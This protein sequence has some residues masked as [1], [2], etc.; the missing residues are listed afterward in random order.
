MVADATSSYVLTDPGF[1][2]D[3]R[4]EALSPARATR[5]AEIVATLLESVRVP[6]DAD[7]L[8]LC[9]QGTFQAFRPR[10]AW[11]DW[12]TQQ[13]AV[14]MFRINRCE[15]IERRLRYIQSLRAIDCWEADQR[16]AIDEFVKMLADDPGRAYANLHA[17]V[18]GCD[19]LIDR[20][21]EL[22]E[23][24]VEA[25]TEAQHAFARSIH[26]GKANAHRQP[27]FAAEFTAGLRKHREQVRTTDQALR[28][29]AEADLSTEV[30]PQLKQVRRDRQAYQ[31]QLNW[32][33]KQLHR[34]QPEH[35]TDYRFRP[36]YQQTPLEPRPVVT[37]AE[38]RPASVAGVDQ[39]N[40]TVEANTPDDQTN[41]TSEPDFSQVEIQTD[42]AI[43]P[44][45]E[46]AARVEARRRRIDP[47]RAVKA[48]RQAKRRSA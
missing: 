4:R 16:V 19:W 1:P 10:N 14:Q 47:E 26:P 39:T 32:C 23:R 17:T 8:Q 42:L 12:L 13:A 41:P 15:R 27:G 20:W 36:D 43:D 25:W 6:E 29:M 3:S 45:A 38:S 46:R 9:D 31:R 44:I 11:E 28:A 2:A 24:P 37:P 22:A 34:P 7:A 18:A 40:P 5:R 30:S 33:I 48:L 21:E 35:R